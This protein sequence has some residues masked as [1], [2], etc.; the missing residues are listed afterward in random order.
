MLV[1]CSLDI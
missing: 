1:V